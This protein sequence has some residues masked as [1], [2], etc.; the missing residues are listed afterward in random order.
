MFNDEDPNFQITV[1][2]ANCCRINRNEGK[3]KKTN[4]KIEEEKNNNLKA[5]NETN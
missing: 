3:Q 4:G 1:T 5:F 2:T